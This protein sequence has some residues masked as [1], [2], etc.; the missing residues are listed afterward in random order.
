[1]AVS[2]TSIIMFSGESVPVKSSPTKPHRNIPEKTEDTE[3]FRR[4][5]RDSSREMKDAK[6]DSSSLDSSLDFD[7]EVATSNK[8]VTYFK[9]FISKE[10][11]FVFV[12]K[13]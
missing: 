4:I 7:N 11:I 5:L 10:D 12:K 9:T 8:R 6:N 1:M 13:Y 3:I 2:F